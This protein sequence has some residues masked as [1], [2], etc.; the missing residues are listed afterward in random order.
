MKYVPASIVEKTEIDTIL[1][2]HDPILCASTGG[3]TDGQSQTSIYAESCI[4]NR[5]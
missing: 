4:T 1:C 2:G 3:R 5:P